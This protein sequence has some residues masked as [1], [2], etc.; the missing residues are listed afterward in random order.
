VGVELLPKKTG[1]SYELKHLNEM[2]AIANNYRIMQIMNRET[3][4]IEEETK[5]LDKGTS[6]FS[7][8][9][10]ILNAKRS[11]YYK[12]ITVF[13]ES[14]KAYIYSINGDNKKHCLWY[15]YE[16]N[17]NGEARDLFKD[18]ISEDTKKEKITTFNG[19][20][21]PERKYYN[22]D[23]TSDIDK[24]KHFRQISRQYFR[25]YAKYITLCV[26]N[27]KEA[28]L[29]LVDKLILKKYKKD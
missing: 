14:V 1:T 23:L 6:E 13:E 11:E 12:A 28:S 26:E 18:I 29:N 15:F 2:R 25:Y 20:V 5:G 7:R 10:S 8:L 22:S 16:I 17:Y 24:L 9:A 4:A 3:S 19:I 27:E 21:V